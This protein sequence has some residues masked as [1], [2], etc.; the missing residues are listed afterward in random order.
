MIGLPDLVPD[1]MCCYQLQDPLAA[2]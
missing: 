1:D 2:E